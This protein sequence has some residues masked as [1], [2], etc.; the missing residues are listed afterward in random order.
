MLSQCADPLIYLLIAAILVSVEAWGVEGAE[1]IPVEA[2]VIGD[3]GAKPVRSKTEMSLCQARCTHGC[4]R[5]LA[6]DQ[7]RARARSPDVRPH[8]PVAA[9]PNGRSSVA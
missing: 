6:G 3:R 9:H 4:P 7:P 8:R 2:I 5:S 1:G